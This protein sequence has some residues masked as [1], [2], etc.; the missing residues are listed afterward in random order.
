MHTKPLTLF[1]AAYCF[2]SIAHAEV[3]LE[4]GIN[5]AGANTGVEGVNRRILTN[6]STS[7]QDYS[8]VRGVFDV[9]TIFVPSGG[10]STPSPAPSRANSKP[11]FYLGAAVD[12]SS[13]P[14][15]PNAGSANDGFEIDAG[16]QYEWQ[17]VVATT[18]DPSTGVVTTKT[19]PSGYI[20]FVNSH[21]PQ[22][23][24]INDQRQAAGAWRCGPE[25]ENPSVSNFELSWLFE[26]SRIGGTLVGWNGKLSI[27]ATD[28]NEQ[29]R[30]P[31]DGGAGRHL[32]KSTHKIN[33]KSCGDENEKSC[34][35]Y[36]RR[37]WLQS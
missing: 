24:P 33:T 21:T 4:A 36:P 23:A 6:A 34:G 37:R 2:V 3:P 32:R 11:T 17:A 27:I 28:A 35:D 12:T 10:F 13:D 9:P 26:P 25:T 31:N 8:G 15:D 29:P 16:V 5:V 18:T 14:N 19:V 22:Y 30:D 20:I 7:G 1:I